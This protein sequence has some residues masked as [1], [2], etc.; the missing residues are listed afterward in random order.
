MGSIL[1]IRSRNKVDSGFQAIREL[2]MKLCPDT[3]HQKQVLRLAT[4]AQ[5]TESV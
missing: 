4:L 2:H 3:K 5:V 1:Q